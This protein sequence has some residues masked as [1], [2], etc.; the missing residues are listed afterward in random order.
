MGTGK[1]AA[2][3]VFPVGPGRDQG[4]AE[5]AFILSRIFFGIFFS[6][7]LP[8]RMTAKSLFSLPLWRFTGTVRENFSGR[9]NRHG[10]SKLASPIHLRYSLRIISQALEIFQ[11]T[12][13][14]NQETCLVPA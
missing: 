7:N 11:T 1:K 6:S 3:D 9:K 4:F 5:I 13:P 8:F 14:L 12:G 2:G 10:K